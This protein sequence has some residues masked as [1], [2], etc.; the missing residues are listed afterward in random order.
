MG[1]P[2]IIILS[3]LG[4]GLL[5]SAYKHGESRGEYNIWYSLI[6]TAIEI[7]ILAWGGFFK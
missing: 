7:V 5:L 2:Q 6:A 4:V 3:L 1:V